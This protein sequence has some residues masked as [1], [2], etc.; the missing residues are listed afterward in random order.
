[1]QTE[2]QYFNE[3]KLQLTQPLLRDFGTDVNNARIVINKNN[4]HISLLDFRE[5]LEDTLT[6]LEQ[7]YWQLVQAQAEVDIQQELL[8]NT[9]KTADT[10][11]R[12]ASRT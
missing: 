3:L 7:N 11:W 5:K 1:M 12:A 2:T 6:K 4:Q 8:E 9:V 10:L